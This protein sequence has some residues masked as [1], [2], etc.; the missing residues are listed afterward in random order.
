MPANP[1]KNENSLHISTTNASFFS[2]LSLSLSFF[3]FFSFL[4]G[5]IA[6]HLCDFMIC[7]LLIAGPVIAIVS[8]KAAIFNCDLNWHRA[9][10]VKLADL[11]Q[12]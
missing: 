7:Q 3:L 8:V 1:Q 5:I 2:S 6:R 9:D 4:V 11:S 10:N 12:F